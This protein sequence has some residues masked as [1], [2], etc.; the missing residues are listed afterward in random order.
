MCA[1][2]FFYP[3][4]C[5]AFWAL[6]YGCCDRAFIHAGVVNVSCGTSVME[7]SR[8]DSAGSHRLKGS[9]PSCSPAEGELHSCGC[10]TLSDSVTSEM[11]SCSWEGRK[12]TQP[13][14][15]LLVSQ[16]GAV[17]NNCWDATLVPLNS[18]LGIAPCPSSRIS[19]L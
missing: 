10:C 6:S 15:L 1:A 5:V 17:C 7:P 8:S 4:L 2:F 19:S 13:L 11:P 12:H 16:H 14:C 3:F 9:L 18:H